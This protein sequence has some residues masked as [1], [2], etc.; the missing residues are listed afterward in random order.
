[1]ERLCRDHLR[2]GA[3]MVQVRAQEGRPWYGRLL[4]FEDEELQRPEEG[5]GAVG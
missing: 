5:P 3:H 2:G 1:M 4:D